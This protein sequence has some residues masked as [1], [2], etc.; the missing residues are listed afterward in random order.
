MKIRNIF[1][2]CSCFKIGDGSQVAFWHDVWVAQTSLK[3]LFQDLFSLTLNS[4]I[5]VQDFFAMQEKTHLFHVPLNTREKDSLQYM[6]NLISEVSL[7]LRNDSLVLKWTDKQKFTVKSFYRFLCHRGVLSAFVKINWRLP[8]PEQ[9]KIFNGLV[10][11]NRIQTAS[12]LCRRNIQVPILYSFR[13]SEEETV[14]HLFRTCSHSM[15]IWQLITSL[16]GMPHMPISIENLWTTWRK[17]LLQ[18]LTKQSWDC[19]VSAVC[20]RL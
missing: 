12:N 7:M 6:L 11:K 10:Y 4:F 20:W 2:Q 9:V 5:S 14:N 3:D 18:Q 17:M 19:L 8:I 1:A 13:N 15:Q 16:L